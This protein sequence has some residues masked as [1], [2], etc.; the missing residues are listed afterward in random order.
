MIKVTCNCGLVLTCSERLATSNVPP[1]T[2]YTFT[3]FTEKENLGTELMRSGGP[4]AL[5]LRFI[6]LVFTTPCGG[7]FRLE[8]NT[9]CSRFLPQVST[10]TQRQK[11]VNIHIQVPWH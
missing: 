6:V 5:R 10:I 2:I 4:F 9:V 7:D 8:H 1:A 11:N 3:W